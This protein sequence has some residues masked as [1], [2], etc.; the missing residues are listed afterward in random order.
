VL[1][2]IVPFAS[3]VACAQRAAWQL[4]VLAGAWRRRLTFA[5]IIAGLLA[6]HFFAWLI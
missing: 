1:L 6:L 3:M 4:A 5:T 2:G